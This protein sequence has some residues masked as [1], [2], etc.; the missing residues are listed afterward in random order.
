MLT[1]HEKEI[2]AFYYEKMRL[3]LLNYIL[4][5][6]KERDRLKIKWITPDYPTLIIRAP[7]PWHASYNLNKQ[8]M[9]RHFYNGNIVVLQIRDLWEDLYSDMLIVSVD[10]LED[11]GKFPLELD[12]L[13][14]QID[15]LCAESRYIFMSK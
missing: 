13:E 8:L 6:P 14:E 7:V 15:R 1:T 12:V 2:L 10:R 11:V 4:K 3:N 5:D 9:E